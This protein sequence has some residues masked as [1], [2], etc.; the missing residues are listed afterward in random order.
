MVPKNLLKSPFN[1]V[2]TLLRNLSLQSTRV[3]RCV[4]ESIDLLNI[5]P[6]IFVKIN[7]NLLLWKM[8]LI[9][10]CYFWNFQKNC[11]KEKKITHFV[12]NSPNPVTLLTTIN[13][14]P[15][16]LSCQGKRQRQKIYLLK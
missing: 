5:A 7:T 4:F 9:N 12:E 1:E 16:N 11:P 13:A 10:L 14:E 2:Y 6:P 8:Q 3:T 15:K